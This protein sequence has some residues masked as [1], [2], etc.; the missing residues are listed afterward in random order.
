M[1]PDANLEEREVSAVFSF[2]EN[3]NLI[4]TSPDGEGNG[5]L[6]KNL[7]TPAYLFQL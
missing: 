5:L 1:D 2:D 3:F 4:W 6:F 7:Y